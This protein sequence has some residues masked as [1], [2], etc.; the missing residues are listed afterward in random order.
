MFLYLVREKQ[1]TILHN[2]NEQDGYF[3]SNP[4]HESYLAKVS[5]VPVDELCFWRTVRV[6]INYDI[7][8]PHAPSFP[9]KIPDK[10]VSSCNSSHSTQHKGE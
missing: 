2:K 1:H 7:I 8:L 3:S 5:G 10:N 6:N 4:R 9:K